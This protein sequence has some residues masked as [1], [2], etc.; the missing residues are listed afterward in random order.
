MGR[1]D[2]RVAVVTGSTRGIGRATAE[3]FA[4][5]GARVVVTGRDRDA[6]D[7][8]AGGI[9]DAGGDAVFVAADLT[10]EAD[11]AA[12]VAAAV[13]RYG[14][15]TTL[16]NNAAPMD[17]VGPG[18]RDGPLA[19]VTDE[20]W[21]A[22]LAGA[23]RSVV[24]CCRHAV[25]AMR[26]AG[27]GAVVNVSSASS[28]RGYP[29]LAAY[30]AAKGALNALTRSAAVELAADGVRVNTVVAG[31]VLSTP[32]SRAVVDD[33]VRGRALRARHLTRLGEPEDIANVAL[34]LA[35][36][37]AAFVTGAVVVADGGMTA[38]MP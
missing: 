13:A 16:V 29:G 14:A 20:G 11:V 7:E 1:L 8:V 21:E 37:E 4:A 36:D 23:L 22:V 9:R 12:L 30:T 31:M 25:P 3:R 10:V 24:W 19:T 35:S 15:V 34:F 38:R 2:G 32:A 17:L 5:E 33:P 18:G 26:D 6:G 27:G 28:V